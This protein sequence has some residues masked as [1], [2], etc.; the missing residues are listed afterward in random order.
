MG[1][2]PDDGSSGHLPL[3]TM[4]GWVIARSLGVGDRSGSESVSSREVGMR[5]S[6]R[7]GVFA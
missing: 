2:F 3:P 7:G 1:G 5:V 6:R 4:L